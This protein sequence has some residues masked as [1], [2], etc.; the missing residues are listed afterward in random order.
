MERKDIQVN[1]LA[2]YKLLKSQ[3]YTYHEINMIL[4]EAKD[5]NDKE[6]EDESKS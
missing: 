4:N 2:I 6:E 5:F 3:G 1:G